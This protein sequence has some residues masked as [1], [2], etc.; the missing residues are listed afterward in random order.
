MNPDTLPDEPSELE[1]E[2]AEPADPTELEFTDMPCTDAGTEADE[3]QWEAF[4]P[5]D[6]EWDPQPEPGDFWVDDQLLVFPSPYLV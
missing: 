4:V 1:P 5:D 2:P 3:S 6:D